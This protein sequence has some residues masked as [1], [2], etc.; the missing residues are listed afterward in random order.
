MERK[1]VVIEETEQEKK[2][3]AWEN[4]MLSIFMPAVGLVAFIIGIVGFSL[5]VT[6]NAGVG[7]FLIILAILGLAG[8]AYG[9]ID[10]VKRRNNRYKKEKKEPDQ[11]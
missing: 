8:I 3:I 2:A 5:I 10:F 6:K 11:Q 1:S 9:V 4:K 7:A